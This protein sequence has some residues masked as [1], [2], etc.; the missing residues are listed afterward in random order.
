MGLSQGNLRIPP[1]LRREGRSVSY[2]FNVSRFFR[3]LRKLV[4]W[5][6]LRLNTQLAQS[7]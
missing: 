3:D 4:L 1:A 7:R 2:K 6:A 5:M